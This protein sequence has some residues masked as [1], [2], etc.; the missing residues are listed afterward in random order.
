[1]NI[2]KCPT[3]E[4][5]GHGTSL[6]KKAA[7]CGI[8]LLALPLV[9]P[10]LAV[11]LRDQTGKVVVM[12]YKARRIVSL[13]PNITELVFALG[14]GNAVAGCCQH[15]NYPPETQSLP[16][17]G[18]YY[19]PDL[20]LIVTLRPD[21]CLAVQD[22]TP[23]IVLE[24]LEQLGIPV[25][26]LNP[27]SLEGLR[28]ALLLLGAAL[29]RR[30]EAERLAAD[31]DERLARVDAAVAAHLRLRGHRPTVLVQVQAS[32]FMVAARGTYP[33]ELVERTGGYIPLQGSVMY[34]RLS[35]EDLLTLKPDV[36]IAP[37][38]DA[39]QP[40]SQ[41][42]AAFAVPVYNVPEDLLFRPSL[43]SLDAL[44]RIVALLWPQGAPV[45]SLVKKVQ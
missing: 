28:E 21:L 14:A 42:G 40:E 9:S 38:D 31:M 20:E 45:V 2:K 15:S 33:A 16:R 37:G 24:R 41:H 13:A 6:R 18:S 32:P 35:A 34:P 4:N 26:T 7:L 36:I 25:L 22:G 10:A 27:Q 5:E 19:R 43:R 11:E 39:R 30:E 3:G 1:M 8:F 23:G 12:P 44:D 29:D 17:V